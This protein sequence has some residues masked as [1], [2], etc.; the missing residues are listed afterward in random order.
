M[1]LEDQICANCAAIMRPP[2]YW[3]HYLTNIDYTNST[4]I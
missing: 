2:K 3:V 4:E 1:L